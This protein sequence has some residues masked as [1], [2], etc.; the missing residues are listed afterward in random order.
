M[1][2]S[3]EMRASDSDR[4]RVAT[5]LREH[6]AQGRIDVD[7]FNER[8]EEL[9]RSKTLGELA[10]L[11]SDLPDVDLHVLVKPE[12]APAPAVKEADDGNSL[13]VSW[14]IWAMAS[15]INWAIWFVVG[16]TSSDFP[17]PWPLWVMLPW[18]AVMLVST[19]FRQDG[20]K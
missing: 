15:A 12:P 6:Y 1:A 18:G 7:E 5:S 4:E 17:Y 16:V 19:F 11:T 13:R 14:S 8:V 10:K 9:Y 3:P 2:P 20:K